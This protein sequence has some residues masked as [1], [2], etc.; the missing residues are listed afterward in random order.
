MSKGSWFWYFI[1][2]LCRQ[3]THMLMLWQLLF[4]TQGLL[5]LLALQAL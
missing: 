5:L 1:K 2:D 4:S 3:L